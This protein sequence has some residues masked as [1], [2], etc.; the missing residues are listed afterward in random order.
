MV[1]EATDTPVRFIPGTLKQQIQPLVHEEVAA[2][3]YDP[4]W[5]ELFRRE[6]QYLRANP[7]PIGTLIET[8]PLLE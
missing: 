2:A 5:P 7:P 4:G 1:A 8:E 3:P 6:K